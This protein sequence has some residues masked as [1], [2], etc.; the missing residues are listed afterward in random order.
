MG[1]SFSLLAAL[2]LLLIQL[3]PA[4]ADD[5]FRKLEIETKIAELKARGDY[6]KALELLNLY[7]DIRERQELPQD[8]LL[9]AALRKRAALRRL[10][11]EP[12][13]DL[14]SLWKAISIDNEVFGR[15]HPVVAADYLAIA[16]ALLASHEKAQAEEYYFRA[17]GILSTTYGPEHHVTKAAT[18]KLIAACGPMVLSQR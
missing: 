2:A 14:A 3:A 5:N 17:I 4:Q 10:A 16:D 18:N 1:R 7:I 6:G 8:F 11:N 13:V 9:A 15:D 12:A